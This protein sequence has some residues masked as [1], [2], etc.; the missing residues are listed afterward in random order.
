MSD[1][2]KTVLVVD[3]EPDARDYLETVLVDNGFNV[4]TAKD[5]ADAVAALEDMKPALVTL[6]ITMPEESGIRFYRNLR[7]D[8]EL[9]KTPVVVVTAVTGLG[10]Q[11][12]PFEKFISTRKWLPAPEGFFSK[13]I[14][15]EAFIEKVKEILLEAV[16][17]NDE[18]VIDEDLRRPRVNFMDFGNSALQFRVRFFVKDVLEQ[19][20]VKTVVREHIDRRF[21][22]EGITIP[23]PQRTLS[24]LPPNEDEVIQVQNVQ[25][26]S[27]SINT[28]V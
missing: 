6:D 5:G 4:I 23:F 8:P 18:I 7:E 21:R 2:A 28:Q 12:E 16:T 1:E 19:W 24:V 22:E 13:P 9:A 3:D 15:K 25:P 17:S 11:P 26:Q 10:G 14:D 27:S 20:R